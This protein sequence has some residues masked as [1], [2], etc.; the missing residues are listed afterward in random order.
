MRLPFLVLILVILLVLFAVFGNRITTAVFRQ[1]AEH[2]SGILLT[3]ASR[4]DTTR[5]ISMKKGLISAFE[6]DKL[7]REDLKRLSAMAD[8][9]LADS[10]LTGEERERILLFVDSLIR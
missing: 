5:V 7:N 9:A 1:G 6:S 8:T 3:N 4:D 10:M 2:F